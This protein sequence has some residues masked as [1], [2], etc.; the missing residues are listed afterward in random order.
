[1]MLGRHGHYSPGGR[2][3]KAA[4]E[5]LVC[6]RAATKLCQS[7]AQLEVGCLELGVKPTRFFQKRDGLFRLALLQQQGTQVFIG[8]GKGGHEVDDFEQNVL[9]LGKLATIA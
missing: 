4:L 5:S 7:L 6:V 9:R 2:Q 3:R 1:M 8:F